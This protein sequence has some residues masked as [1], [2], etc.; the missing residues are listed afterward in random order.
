MTISPQELRIV[1]IIATAY[2][3]ADGFTQ[4]KLAAPLDPL[5]QNFRLVR[6]MEH[7]WTGNASVI[8][9]IDLSEFSV[10]TVSILLE[11]VEFGITDMLKEL[12]N[13]PYTPILDIRELVYLFDKLQPMGMEAVRYEI[14]HSFLTNI[15][16]PADYYAA[17][18]LVPVGFSKYTDKKLVVIDFLNNLMLTDNNVVIDTKLLLDLSQYEKFW[19]FVRWHS[20]TVTLDID[21]PVVVEKFKSKSLLQ[22]I[23]DWY[24]Q[25]ILR[26]KKEIPPE[27]YKLYIETVMF[28]HLAEENTVDLNFGYKPSKTDPVTGLSSRTLHGSSERIG[29][30]WAIEPIENIRPEQ[31]QTRQWHRCLST[32]PEDS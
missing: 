19:D 17:I 1:F 27:Y 24:F 3:Y 7:L 4:V 13:W 32:L 15:E 8:P 11:A 25:D 26:G 18:N 9:E 5:R 6:D 2:S 12:L 30:H 28:P 10:E 22:P 14:L 23:L 21:I 29:H 16:T 20:K 31:K